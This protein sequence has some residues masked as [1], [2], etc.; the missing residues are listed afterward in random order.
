MLNLLTCEFEYG[1]SKC[2]PIECIVFEYA[3]S[4]VKVGVRLELEKRCT[5]SNI[6][7]KLCKIKNSTSN[8]N[9][10]LYKAT[11]FIPNASN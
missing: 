4:D 9:N 6:M 11:P 5:M 3:C 1:F 2:V 8:G 10:E 7:W